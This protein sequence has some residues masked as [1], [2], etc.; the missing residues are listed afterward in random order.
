MKYLICLLFFSSCVTMKPVYSEYYTQSEK[1]AASTDPI[2]IPKR[3]DPAKT[4]RFIVLGEKGIY[5]ILMEK[6]LHLKYYPN[7]CEN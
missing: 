4:K 5:E 7:P 3:F 6:S 2:P 1:F